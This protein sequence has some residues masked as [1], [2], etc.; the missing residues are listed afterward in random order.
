MIT[1]IE[2]PVYYPTPATLRTSFK[3]AVSSLLGHKPMCSKVYEE[4]SPQD[5]QKSAGWLEARKVG[6]DLYRLSILFPM[7]PAYVV[8]L[9]WF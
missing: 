5:E 6:D 9:S 1:I 8:H 4:Q 7:A 2:K 3:Y